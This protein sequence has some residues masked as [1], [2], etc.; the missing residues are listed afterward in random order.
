M[1]LPIYRM[2]QEARG[3]VLGGHLRMYSYWLFA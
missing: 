3:Q 1:G 2:D